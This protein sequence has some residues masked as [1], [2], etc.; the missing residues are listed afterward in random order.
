MYKQNELKFWIHHRNPSGIHNKVS[1]LLG[2]SCWNL[3]KLDFVIKE[4]FISPCD[5]ESYMS[6]TKAISITSAI[7]SGRKELFRNTKEWSWIKNYDRRFLV[8]ETRN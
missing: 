2:K 4:I 3:S 7:I 5:L 1:Y 8:Y 6:W